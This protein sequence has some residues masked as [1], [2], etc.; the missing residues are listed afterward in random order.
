[1][2]AIRVVQKPE[3][4]KLI[5]TVPEELRDE[6]MVIDFRPVRDSEKQSLAEIARDLFQ[7][8][9]DPNPQL[10]WSSLNVYEQ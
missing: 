5:I 1:M 8:L 2:G 10:D 6:T 4:G 9:P 3:N 7:R